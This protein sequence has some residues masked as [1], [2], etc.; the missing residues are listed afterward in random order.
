MVSEAF[1]SKEREALA[2][3]RVCKLWNRTVDRLGGDL[4][5]QAV[6]SRFTGD[7]EGQDAIRDFQADLHF[8]CVALNNL[9]QA[10]E[11]ARDVTRDPA[12]GRLVRRF[13]REL[14]YVETVRGIHEHFVE[15]LRGV[16]N[17][18]ELLDQLDP[19]YQRPSLKFTGPSEADPATSITVQVG[20]THEMEVIV[21]HTTANAIA[22]ELL[23]ELDRVIK[24]QVWHWF[25]AKP[26]T[27]E[28]REE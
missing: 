4:V 18:Q 9:K 21:A 12:I 28:A 5:N 17:K 23:I 16:G 24:D 13:N 20:P 19:D 3:W 25:D 27:S 7:D 11:F 26:R 10:M 14:P 1:N 22:T 8:F 6:S 2:A 15:Y